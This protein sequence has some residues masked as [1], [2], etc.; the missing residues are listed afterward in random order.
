MLSTIDLSVLVLAG[1]AVGATLAL[2][3]ACTRYP[4]I[5]YLLFVHA[6]DFKGHQY[7]SVISDRVD[8]TVLLGILTCVSVV[9]RLVAGRIHVQLP[10]TSFLLP[11]VLIAILAAVSLTYT[12]SPIYG[13]YKFSLFVT[14][15][16]GVAFLP[17]VIFQREAPLRRF[18]L[19][20]VIFALV[21]TIDAFVVTPSQVD[22]GFQAGSGRTYTMFGRTCAEALLITV[23]YISAGS[24]SLAK[25]GF[26]AILSATLVFALFSCGGKGP[27]LA[28]LLCIMI[29][30]P[31]RIAAFGGR[32]SR[33][34]RRT[35]VAVTSVA[36]SV[37]L[38]VTYFGNHFT[39]FFGRLE[40]AVDGER[41]QLFGAAFQ[42]MM[43]HPVSG[44]G[45][46]GYASLFGM[47]DTGGVY[48]HNILLEVGAEMGILGALSLS[49]L[50]YYSSRSGLAFLR[51][52]SPEYS[53]FAMCFVVLLINAVA[54]A[55]VACDING[56]RALF[57]W[58]GV[59]V[60]VNLQ[61]WRALRRPM[62]ADGRRLP[63]TRL[64]H[65]ASSSLQGAT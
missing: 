42:A 1:V 62:L 46:G 63:R 27:L 31:V 59:V 49:F 34:T 32:L 40:T 50:L 47:D 28:A 36:T 33:A 61:S 56:N 16:A 41:M 4:E 35:L 10:P 55:C 14:I 19:G 26:V 43:S 57:G 12:P 58:M 20:L 53:P 7:L 3:V 64:P 5:L 65:N 52:P 60:A 24:P 45:I 22:N 30:V 44:L 39:T 11:Y 51:N 2:I 48:P 9:Y 13:A 38:L 54:N 29:S 37:I 8:L 6:G 21:L 18:L 17:F 25:R 15:T 23:I